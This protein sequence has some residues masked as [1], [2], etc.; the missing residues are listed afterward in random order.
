MVNTLEKQELPDDEISLS[1]ERVELSGLGDSIKA[2]GDGGENEQEMGQVRN[3]SDNKKKEISVSNI[4]K[5]LLDNFVGRVNSSRKE[6]EAGGN[7]K[8]DEEEEEEEEKSYKKYSYLNEE[9]AKKF[10]LDYISSENSGDEEQHS[11]SWSQGQANDKIQQNYDPSNLE[12]EDTSESK[13]NLDSNEYWKKAPTN[14][15]VHNKKNPLQYDK[16]PLIKISSLQ[17]PDFLSKKTGQTANTMGTKKNTLVDMPSIKE[18]APNPLH[19]SSFWQTGKQITRPSSL[20][21]DNSGPVTPD[22]DGKLLPKSIPDNDYMEIISKDENES[23]KKNGTPKLLR[24]STAFLR[25][26]I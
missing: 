5:L 3:A 21:Y 25:Y 12:V 11:Y 8:D 9:E 20:P 24:K 7:P 2:L 18:A 23:S 16:L 13:P 10:K 14:S 19:L 6:Q 1:F 22:I 26:C 15:G 4:S 17:E